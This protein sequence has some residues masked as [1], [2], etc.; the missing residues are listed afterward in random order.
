MRPAG[1]LVGAVLEGGAVSVVL[2]GLHGARIVVLAFWTGVTRATATH[3]LAGLE[4]GV[5]NAVLAGVRVATVD[6]KKEHYHY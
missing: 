3:V 6:R 4:V 5:A 1:T 2:A